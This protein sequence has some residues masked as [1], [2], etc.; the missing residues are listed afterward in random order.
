MNDRICSDIDLGNV[1]EINANSNCSLVSFVVRFC[2]LTNNCRYS[3]IFH[4]QADLGDGKGFV[5]VAILSKKFCAINNKIPPYRCINYNVPF[6]NVVIDVPICKKVVK[7]RIKLIGINCVGR[8]KCRKQLYKEGNK[9][10]YSNSFCN[11]YIGKCVIKIP[12]C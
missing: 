12:N 5:N 8:I 4:L 3:V 11:K 9:L 7:Y 6:N 2:R 10:N 1:A